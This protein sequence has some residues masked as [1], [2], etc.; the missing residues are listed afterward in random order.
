[1]HTSAVAAPNAA[2]L[3]GMCCAEGV[4]FSDELQ[5]SKSG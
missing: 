2:D 3:A 1:M 4:E 5:V